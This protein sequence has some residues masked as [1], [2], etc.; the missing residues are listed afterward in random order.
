[1]VGIHAPEF[2]L[3]HVL[4][5]VVGSVAAMGIRFPVGQDDEGRT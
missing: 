5:N 2:G 4:P 1:M 3:G